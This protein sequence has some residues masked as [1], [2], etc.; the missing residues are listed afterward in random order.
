MDRSFYKTYFETE[1]DHWWFRV[2]R[3]IIFSLLKKYG[4]SKDAKIFD[5]GCGSGYT[6]GFLQDLGFGVSGADV[7]SEAVE[8][9]RSRGI[10]NLSVAS[11]SGEI[12]YQESAFDCILA[13]DVLE[14]IK[15]DSIAIKSIEKSLKPG[16][17]AFITVPAYMWLWGVQDEISKHY[18]RYAI[19]ELV[20]T[21]GK[22]SNLKIIKKSYFNT[23]LFPGVVAV[24]FLS[25]IFVLKE[26]ESD[27][28]VNSKFLNKIFYFIFNIESKLLQFADFPFGV[29]ILIVLK[30]DNE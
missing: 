1:K 7:S 21:I 2:R 16:G 28:D 6:A 29:S 23:F 25:K 20:E 14:H 26:R 11:E 5:F 18:R 3:N 12:K 13:L 30:K 10:K 19:G 24:R 4:I 8:F 17:V 9:G 27:F 22:S 15:N